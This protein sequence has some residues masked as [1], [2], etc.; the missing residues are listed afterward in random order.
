MTGQMRKSMANFN[1]FVHKGQNVISSKAFNRK[2]SNT[3]AQQ[4]HRAR[5]KLIS[6]AYQSLGGYGESGFPVRPERMSAFNQF[7]ALNL[8]AA[9]DASGDV[10]V[11]DYSKMVIAK[12]TLAPVNDAKA[13]FGATGITISCLSN[14]DFPKVS[15]NDV[16][17]V[18][19][20]LKTGALY[21]A[22]QPR[23][24]QATISVLLALP[25]VTANDMEFVYVF[26]TTV[27]GKK[28]SNSVFVALE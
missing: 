10:P 17:I 18:L 6:D 13:T 27:D 23:G 11:I 20:K 4:L 12:G 7:M 24:N 9:I 21:A 22:R 5:F 26:V 1:T 2:D 8:P 16:V 25:T 28:A 15:V 3:E 19:G 14:I